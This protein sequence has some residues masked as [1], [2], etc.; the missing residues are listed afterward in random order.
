MTELASFI[1]SQIRIAEEDLHQIVAKF[2]L[3]EVKKGRHL[4]K[5]GQIA[6]EYLFIR[7]GGLRIYS[8][9]HE[10]EFTGWI[11]FEGEFFGEL[12]SL[13]SQKPI[14][15]LD[16]IKD[17]VYHLS[18]IW[19]ILNGIRIYLVGATWVYTFKSYLAIQKAKHQNLPAA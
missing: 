10:Q 18:V 12:H 2:S 16:K 6:S 13:K 7:K 17:E 3:R 8:S 14:G 15:D 4:L 5:Q 19:I 9:L 1:Q 11:A